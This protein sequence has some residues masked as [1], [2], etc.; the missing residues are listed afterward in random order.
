MA[1]PLSYLLF[2]F[3][4]H[5]LVK[6]AE[7]GVR[8]VGMWGACGVVN[9]SPLPPLCVEGSRGVSLDVTSHCLL[10]KSSSAFIGSGISTGTSGLTRTE[11][12]CLHHK[13]LCFIK[14]TGLHR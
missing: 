11:I 14:I 9:S 3:Y 6:L 7:S 8:V 13:E 2:S 10:C 5:P 1:T 12:T 4:L